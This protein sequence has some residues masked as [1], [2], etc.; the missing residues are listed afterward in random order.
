[1]IDLV[2]LEFAVI[3]LDNSSLGSLNAG[4]S[5]GEAFQRQISGLDLEGDDT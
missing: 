4:S 3:I 2:E 1:L 5:D